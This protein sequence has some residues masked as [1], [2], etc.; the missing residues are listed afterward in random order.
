[1]SQPLLLTCDNKT[2]GVVRNPFE[3][4]VTEYFY[5]FNYIGFDKWITKFTPTPQVE[6]F[7]KIA[8]TL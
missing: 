2:I 5:S 3:R 8:I 7:I 6:L 4:V 1:M